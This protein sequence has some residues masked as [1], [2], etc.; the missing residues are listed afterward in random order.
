MTLLFYFPQC[1]YLQFIC[2]LEASSKA[3]ISFSIRA[4]PFSGIC[5]F[6]NFVRNKIYVLECE[7]L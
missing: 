7:M 2:N 4:N 1:E 6:C 3:V 5:L